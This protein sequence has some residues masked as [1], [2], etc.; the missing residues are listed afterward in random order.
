[1]QGIECSQ[2]AAYNRNA[3]EANNVTKKYLLT[4]NTAIL[5][6]MFEAYKATSFNQSWL[7]LG[8]PVS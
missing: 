8:H 7:A 3:K 5:I 6:L 2:L 1:M 4:V